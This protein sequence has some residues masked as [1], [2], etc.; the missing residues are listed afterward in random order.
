MKKKIVAMMLAGMMACSLW[1]CG[2]NGK[3]VESQKEVT[4]TDSSQESTE[5]EAQEE[6]SGDD[7]N[8][9]EIVEENGMRK[10]PVVTEKELNQTGQTG[11]VIYTIEGLQVSKLTAT[12]DEMA[13]MLGIEKDKEVALVAFNA[14]IENTTDA[15][16]SFY[17]GQATLTTNTKEQV[18]SDGFLSEYIDG[19]ML[20]KV[21]NSG[22]MIYI[23]K[24]SKAEDLTTLTLH[25]DAPTD[26]NFETIGDPVTI[27]FNLQ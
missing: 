27:D 11:P 9:G 23:L 4:A 7:S 21:K 5:D 20:G 15:T 22:N 14:S 10:E 2:D 12:T 17:L 24:N 25:V 18:D 1:A 26:E 13:E 6:A 8:T 3:K 16:V 19:E